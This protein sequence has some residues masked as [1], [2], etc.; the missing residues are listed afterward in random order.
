[1]SFIRDCDSLGE[2]L[3]LWQMLVLMT[4]EVSSSS[5]WLLP[6]NST[7]NTPYLGRWVFI[8]ELVQI[9]LTFQLPAKLMLLFNIIKLVWQ[10]KLLHGFLIKSNFRRWQRVIMKVI[11]IVIWMNSRCALLGPPISIP[12]SLYILAGYV[13]RADQETQS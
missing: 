8:V 11:I 10:S 4:M 2:G 3:L 5:L 13:R 9:P 12:Y 6:Q 1:M 7:I